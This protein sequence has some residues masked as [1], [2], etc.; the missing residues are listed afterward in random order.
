ME[1]GQRKRRK[2]DRQT[3]NDFKLAIR[4]NRGNFF[5]LLKEKQI[6]KKEI[7]KKHMKNT[8][9]NSTNPNF[10]DDGMEVNDNVS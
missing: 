10:I 7:Q 8:S 2:K 1:I 3:N 4:E 6:S 9:L 5:C